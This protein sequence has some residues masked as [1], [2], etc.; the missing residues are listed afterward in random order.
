MARA[1]HPQRKATAAGS[2]LGAGR[3][4]NLVPGRERRPARGHDFAAVP[5]QG[6]AV[7]RR[8]PDGP[9]AGAEPAAATARPLFSKECSGFQR[10][11]VIE[12]LVHARQLVDSA[13]GDL[14]PVASGSVTSGRI[15]DLVNVHFHDPAALATAAS[16]VLD[17]FRLVRAELN[18]P[19]RY[20]C[21]RD[22]A[23]DCEVTSTGL[24]GGFTTCAS[25]ADVELCSPYYVSLDCPEQARVLVHEL[26]HH[27]PDLCP[28]RA[29]VGEAA[30]MALPPGH[31]RTNP[32]TYAQFAT[33]AFH[34][35]PSCVDCGF[36]VQRPGGR[37]Y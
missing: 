19:I 37:Q 12:P 3:P 10:C 14:G 15:V 24:V 36:E 13:I 32:D 20:V 25:G 33:M 16:F 27:V 22:E 5:V 35:A 23:A 2:V 34:G 28:D 17:K 4:R 26:A 29:Y 30:Y 6:P 7:I 1:T 11:S 8:Q 9:P 21:R 18:A 31:A